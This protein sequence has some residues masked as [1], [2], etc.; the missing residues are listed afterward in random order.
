MILKLSSHTPCSL[1]DL[2]VL[3]THGDMNEVWHFPSQKPGGATSIR[4]VE[5]SIRGCW[6]FRMGRSGCCA[7]RVF[8]CSPDLRIE[9]RKSPH[10]IIEFVE[11]RQGRFVVEVLLSATGA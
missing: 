11:L 9:R 6:A 1:E 7:G 10:E 4:S 5:W 3:I 2:E 8:L